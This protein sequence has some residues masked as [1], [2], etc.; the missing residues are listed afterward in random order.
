VAKIHPASSQ[1][2]PAHNAL[3]KGLEEPGPRAHLVLLARSEDELLPTIVSRCLLLR[4]DE[5]SPDEVREVLRRRGLSAEEADQRARWSGG[6][7][8]KALAPEAPE[9][10]RLAELALRALGDGEAW[11]DPMSLVDALLAHCDQGA[12]DLA[13]KRERLLDLLRALTRGLR[14]ALVARAG[15]GG[16]APG[17][18]GAL[19]ALLEPLLRLPAG[20]LEAALE[21]LGR[22]EEEVQEN[23]NPTLVIEG[24]VLDLGETLESRA[25]R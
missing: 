15:A 24:L 12:A 23:V 11:Q 21:R 8:G 16:R 19:P 7:P 18:S 1:T 6:S 10:A 4:L 2:E 13:E 14:D 22:A 5:L 3:L 25:P 9:R 20:R 17:L